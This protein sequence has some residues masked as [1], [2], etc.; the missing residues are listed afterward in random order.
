MGDAE[1]KDS[2]QQHAG[3]D[4][5]ATFYDDSNN[6]PQ[7]LTDVSKFSL[8]STST[9]GLLSWMLSGPH[10]QF[11]FNLCEFIRTELELGIT[12]ASLALNSKTEERRLR[13]RENAH[14]A[15]DTARHF[16]KERPVGEPTAQRNL[17]ARL[18]TLTNLLLQ[19]GETLEE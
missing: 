6:A 18:I 5:F 7:L 9:K 12:F 3:F 14:K 15:Y 11:E 19:L 16:W 10:E 17:L 13:C 4:P 8:L 1:I 2:A